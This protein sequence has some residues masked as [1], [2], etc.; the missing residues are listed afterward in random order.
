MFFL[1]CYWHFIQAKLGNGRVFPSQFDS[2]GEIMPNDNAPGQQK[3][4]LSLDINVHLDNL[5]SVTQALADL[6]HAIRSELM[7][8]IQDIKD[9]VAAIQASVDAEKTVDDSVVTLLQ[10]LSAM[11]A[12][13]K[14]QLADAI[15]A[16]ADPAA[17]Q[18]VL[19]GLSAAQTSVDSN[20]AALA[21]AVTANTPAA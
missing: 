11:V 13:L 1:W 15:A 19:D 20:T 7:P 3:K 16:G 8:T 18:A 12:S 14:Q 10:G 5:E 21:S 4:N 2:V 9:K 17:L 6:T